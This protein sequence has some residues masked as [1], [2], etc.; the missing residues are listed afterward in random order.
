[1]LNIAN[2]LLRSTASEAV[3]LF[4]K[5]PHD[6]KS[7]DIF[8]NVCFYH[9]T[10]YLRYLKAR[11]YSF[12][13]HDADEQKSLSDIAY[14]IL[15]DFLHGEKNR[16][17]QIIF[18]YFERHKITHFD[19]VD[20]DLLYDHFTI[21]LR[22]FIRKI[23]YKNRKEQ[24]PQAANLE[25][26]INDI[27]KDDRYDIVKQNDDSADYI[28]LSHNK[29][30]LRK[31]H[32]PLLLTDLLPIAYKSFGEKESNNRVDWVYHIFKELERAE[33]FQNFIKKYDLIRAMIYINE[34][35]VELESN[36]FSYISPTDTISLRGAVEEE[37]AKSFD[38]A[39]K[40]IKNFVDKGKITGHEAELLLIATEKY[41]TDFAFDGQTDKIPTYF[42]EVM[43]DY[44]QRKY[45]KKYKY[46]FETVINTSLED[47]KDRMQNNSIIRSFS[48]YFTSD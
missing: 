28:F 40:T 30:N 23:L 6:R 15:A 16:P 8:F 45:L 46:I 25:R 43:P 9:T 31:N 35:I 44:D 36:W 33:E 22:G 1:M 3:R 10:G 14:D 20:L 29:T 47:F 21:L 39:M 4:L 5:N 27:I 2:K 37:K 42:F 12:D 48:D 38:Y 26:R 32:R 18:D 19:G 17:F 34:S 7:F 41:L 13:L 11:G 24:N